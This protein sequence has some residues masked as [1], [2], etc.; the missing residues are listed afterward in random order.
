[1]TNL[2][3]M[4]QDL[5]ALLTIAASTGMKSGIYILSY[6]N[7]YFESCRSSNPYNL[8][9]HLIRRWRKHIEDGEKLQRERLE[10]PRPKEW[11]RKTT[12]LMEDR[13]SVEVLAS[14]TTKLL[15]KEYRKEKHPYKRF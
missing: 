11:Q 5:L 6:G 8:P 7:L 2:A 1:M 15:Y 9:E 13:S 10:W 14:P 12:L 4:I 3:T